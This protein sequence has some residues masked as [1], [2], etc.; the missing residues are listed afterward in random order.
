MNF[1]TTLDKIRKKINVATSDKVQLPK[2]PF[3]FREKRSIM[4]KH[5]IKNIEQVKN[6][7]QSTEII[8]DYDPATT[9]V[10]FVYGKKDA[11]RL[12]TTKADGSPGY[13]Q[14]YEKSKNNLVGYEQDICYFRKCCYT[15]PHYICHQSCNIPSRNVI[16]V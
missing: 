4:L 11:G 5:G 6:P 14:D 15:M 10:V 13:F 1:Q 9:A 3:N 8:Q 2:S 7:Y 12:R 16:S